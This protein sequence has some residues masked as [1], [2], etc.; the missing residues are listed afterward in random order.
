MKGHS[1]DICRNQKP[2]ETNP[3]SSGAGPS[4]EVK[5][6]IVEPKMNVQTNGWTAVGGE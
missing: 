6:V 5:P 4:G 1:D 2:K 3:G